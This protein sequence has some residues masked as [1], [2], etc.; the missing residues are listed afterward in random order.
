MSLE[1]ILDK[2]NELTNEDKKELEIKIDNIIEKHSENMYKINELVFQSVTSLTTSESRISE[3][4]NQG[5]FKRFWGNLSGKNDKLKLDIDRNLM[6]AQYASQNILQKLA[7]QNLM[8]FELIAAVNN[9]LNTSLLEIDNEINEIYENLIIF[10]KQTRSDI[11]CLENRIDR[12]E[13]NINLLNWINSIEYQMYNGVD[14]L[15]LNYVEKIVCIIRDFYEITKGEWNLSDLLLLKSCIMDIGIGVK[16]KIKI[17]DF[18]KEIC[19]DEKLIYKLLGDNFKNI[20]LNDSSYSS[21][22]IAILKYVKLKNDESYIV[23]MIQEEFN[24]IG[25]EKS[26]ENIV[27]SL[28]S[29]YIKQNQ[30]INMDLELNVFDLILELLFS[31]RQLKLKSDE[32]IKDDNNKKDIELLKIAESL[33]LQYKIKE[34]F[35]I[36]IRLADKGNPRAMYFCEEI[37]RFGY[38]GIPVNIE[39]AKLILKKGYDMKDPMCSIN[40]AYILKYDGKQRDVYFKIFEQNFNSIYTLAE[41]GDVFA[42]NELADLYDGN[43]I[44]DNDKKLF[45]LRKSAEGGYWRSINKLN[46]L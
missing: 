20:N 21:I 15:D 38:G 44:N 32:K 36:F 11:V 26:T 10:F 28:I 6:K 30:K 40:Y 22:I 37:L 12:M 41:E 31:F 1:L 39:K 13:K 8:S 19:K 5:F 3:L 4:D 18:V 16:D 17:I 35:D 46:N 43:Y 45:W 14:Y 24:Y 33:F 34:A 25:I 23:K 42:Q 29:S 2:K 9:K 27:F 7:E